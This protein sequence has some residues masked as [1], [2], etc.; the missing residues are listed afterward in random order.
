MM[1]KKLFSCKD[2]VAVVTGGLGLI[3]KEIAIALNEF[4]A[5]VF[6]ADL[7]KNGPSITKGKNNIEFIHFDITSETIMSKAL[8]TII[9]RYGK[10]DIFIN[11]AYPKTKDWGEKLEKI[12]FESW[13]TNVN[14]HLGGYFLSSRMAAETMKKSGGGTII[15]IASIYGIVGPDFSIYENTDITM[16]AAYSAIKG[17]VISFTKYL[18]TYYA[19]NNIRANVI[20]PGGILD[21]QPKSF[22]Q[23][24]AKKTPLGRMGRPTDVT[25]AVIFLS[26]DAS[27]YITGQNIVVDGGW[28]AW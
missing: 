26:S 24:Y 9:K 23:K 12:P 14:D 1:Y 17:G 5:K 15:N 19:E 18:A 4:E 21:R 28:T 8:N 27:S 25:G 16:P 6:I 20:S 10:I 7:S 11:S 3:G 2:K 13:K 22:V